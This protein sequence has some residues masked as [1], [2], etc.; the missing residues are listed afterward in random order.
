MA[1]RLGY[2]ALMHAHGHRSI[3]KTRNI[4]MRRSIGFTAL[5]G[6]VAGFIGGFAEIAWIWGYETITEGDAEAVAQ[7]V[8]NAVRLGGEM[9]PLTL[10]GVTVHL[11]LAAILGFAI[12][13]TLRPFGAY[14]SRPAVYG[15]VLT[16]LATVWAANFFV[17]LPLLSPQF[18]S[19]VP[20]EVSLASKLSFGLA[21]SL[22]LHLAGLSR[23]NLLRA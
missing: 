18:V 14:L 2:P 22:F 13:L 20:Y 5:I 4:M 3:A 17:I 9:M 8:A 15:I 1:G 11:S 19:I 21:T 12:V 16:T 23:P 6:V 7:A 10:A